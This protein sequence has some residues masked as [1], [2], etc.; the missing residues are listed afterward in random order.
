MLENFPFSQVDDRLKRAFEF[1]EEK[2]SEGVIKN[3]GIS[4]WSG[5]RVPSTNNYWMSLEKLAEIAE[6]VGGKENNF[7]YISLPI[8]LA[9]PEAFIEEYQFIGT[10]STNTLTAAE[11]LRLNVMVG[12]PLMGGLMSQTP[13]PTTQLLS[14][15]LVGKHLNLMR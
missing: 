11:R 4:S 14:K 6:A 10:E 5:F 1:L 15:N 8:N 7:N 9:M 3:Y 12:S 13:L 2:V